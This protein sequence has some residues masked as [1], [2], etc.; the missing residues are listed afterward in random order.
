MLIILNTRIKT[1]PLIDY[2]DAN[3]VFWWTTGIGKR[4]EK[5]RKSHVCTCEET[6]AKKHTTNKQV[7]FVYFYDI[8]INIDLYIFKF[9]IFQ[10]FNV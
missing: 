10:D 5:L 7:N 4:R 1:Y 3:I 8:K 9:L 6:Q 2:I